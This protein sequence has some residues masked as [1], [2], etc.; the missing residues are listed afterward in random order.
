MHPVTKLASCSQPYRVQQRLIHLPSLRS[1]LII[2]EYSLFPSVNLNERFAALSTYVC[3]F[4]KSRSD[5]I[6]IA[7]RFN[8]IP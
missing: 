8:R 2:A 4:G 3:V 1:A 6:S 5:F 7:K